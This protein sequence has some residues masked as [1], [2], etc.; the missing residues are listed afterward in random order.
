V[1]L[2]YA[3]AKDASVG[4]VIAKYSGKLSRMYRWDLDTDTFTAG[5]F[6]KA[7]A[8]V[9]DI[10]PDGRYVAYY[11]EAFHRREQS[12]IAVGQVPYFTALAFFPTF[13]LNWFHANFEGNERLSL[14]TRR[15]D[16]SYV[17]GFDL[18]QDRID[19]GCP[20]EVVREV[21]SMEIENADRSYDQ[22]R[23]RVIS[24]D[25]QN[26][27][28]IATDRTSKASKVLGTFDREPF[29]AIEPPD[30]ATKW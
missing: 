19:P 5:Q 7:S 28:L 16:H 12:Y 29:Q 21:T 3:I 18:I 14:G 11:A 1:S 6:V 15:Y 20:F 2:T 10:S 17:E 27:R 26:H 8:T 25:H 23:N 9:E 24:L 13:H 30:W 22:R 4:V